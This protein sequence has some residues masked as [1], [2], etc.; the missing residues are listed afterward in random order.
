MKQRIVILTTRQQLKTLARAKRWEVDATFEV[1]PDSFYQLFGIH[2][3][4]RKGNQVKTIPLMYALMSCKSKLAQIK[5]F[6]RVVELLRP[7]KKM[8]VTRICLDFEAATW[9]A[10]RVVLPTVKLQGCDF[11]F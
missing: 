9:G 6:R 2:T 10:I 8:R 4:V 5:L 7:Y 3:T 11:H 1:V